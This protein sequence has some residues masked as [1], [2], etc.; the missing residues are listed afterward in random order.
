MTVAELIAKLKD[1]PQDAPV[2]AFDQGCESLTPVKFA[3]FTEEP[4]YDVEHLAFLMG[5][6]DFSDL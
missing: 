1:A 5:P 2:Y 3:W 4:G 6:F